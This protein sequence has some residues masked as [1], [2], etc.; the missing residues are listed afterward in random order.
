MLVDRP[1]PTLSPKCSAAES[2][3]AFGTGFQEAVFVRPDDSKFD[4]PRSGTT[5]VVRGT[6]AFSRPGGWVSISVGSGASGAGGALS[7]AGGRSAGKTGGALAVAS[8][9]AVRARR[10]AASRN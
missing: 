1:S 2:K 7:A 5:G 4:R 10:R 6:V 9:K 3:F 8:G